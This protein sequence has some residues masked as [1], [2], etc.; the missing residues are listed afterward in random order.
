MFEKCA[1]FVNSFS[2]KYEKKNCFIFI[3]PT[4]N[5]A[6]LQT[7]KPLYKKIS[8]IPLNYLQIVV[9]QSSSSCRA[10]AKTF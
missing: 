3:E 2:V 5:M 4:N 6:E 7:C 1:A 8:N 9:F 10:T